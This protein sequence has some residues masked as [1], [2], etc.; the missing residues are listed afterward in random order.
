[1]ETRKKWLGIALIWA[2]A[3]APNATIIRTAVDIVDPFMWNIIR[4]TPVF[5][6]T[7]PWIIKTWPTIRKPKVF[8]Y[9]LSSGLSMA[10]ALVCLVLAIKTSQASYVSIITLLIPIATIVLS[11]FFLK[12]R[13]TRRA[14]AGVA[15]AALGGMTLV[16]LPLALAKGAISFYP[17]ATLFGLIN[18]F[19]FALAMVLIRRCDQVAHVP[20]AA[21]I[22]IGALFTV[23][24]SGLLFF[25]TGHAAH[26]VRINESVLW[27]ALYSGAWVALIGRILNVQ[28]F[29]KLGAATSGAIVYF[30]TLLAIIIPVFVLHEKLSITMVV[31]G[32]FI[33]LGLYIIEH[34][35]HSHARLHFVWHRS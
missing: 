21:T 19:S 27:A 35:K 20:L 31:G 3:G 10:V 15:L 16:V 6:V 24:I 2:V 9:V 23:I 13:I 32:I 26:P 29:E 22:G 28:I 8:P 14:A 5:L 33:L 11:S 17:L 34:H 4:L 30:E 1:M 7:L 18:C 12:E 25:V